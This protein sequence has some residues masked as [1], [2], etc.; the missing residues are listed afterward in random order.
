MV[1]AGLALLSSHLFREK[2]GGNSLVY[3]CRFFAFMM[4]F[5]F[6]RNLY[7]VKSLTAWTVSALTILSFVQRALWIPLVLSRPVYEFCYQRATLHALSNPPAPYMLIS[8]EHVAGATK[9]GGSVSKRS[10]VD[11]LK[12]EVIAPSPKDEFTDAEAHQS[13]NE[14]NK[15]YYNYV[16]ANCALFGFDIVAQNITLMA[17]LV[18]VPI[19]RAGPNRYRV[20]RG[21]RVD[22]CRYHCQKDDRNIHLS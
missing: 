1:N 17:F 19:L 3:S 11:I 20:G 10:F 15:A 18:I 21:Y 5:G 7:T 9:E 22:Y 14:K 8:D 6:Y 12:S 13:A 2:C 4:Y 16:R